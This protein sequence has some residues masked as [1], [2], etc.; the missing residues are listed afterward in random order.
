MVH[1]PWSIY[2]PF[3]FSPSSSSLS[4]SLCYVGSK[5]AISSSR[6]AKPSQAS[7]PGRQAGNTAVSWSRLSKPQYRLKIGLLSQWEDA[8]R[9]SELEERMR[10]RVGS[11]RWIAVGNKLLVTWHRPGQGWP[12]CQGREARRD[13][14]SYR[15]RGSNDSFYHSNFSINISTAVIS[16]PNPFLFLLLSSR[17]FP[18]FPCETKANYC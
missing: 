18:P 11:R 14:I 4:I 8:G 7:Q 17:I 13:W 16:L 1:R 12:L 15:L 2:S 9:S 3:P 6:I 5:L 10:M